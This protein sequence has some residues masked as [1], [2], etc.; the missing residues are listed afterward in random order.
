MFDVILK[1]F[2]RYWVI[3]I[4]YVLFGNSLIINMVFFYMCIFF[5]E[6]YIENIFK[7]ILV[8]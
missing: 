6:V 4:L 1:L 7:E 8:F 3:I 2:D 5:M